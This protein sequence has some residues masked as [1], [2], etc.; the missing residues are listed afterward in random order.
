MADGWSL[1]DICGTDT[2]RKQMKMPPT[3]IMNPP[4]IWLVEAL[5]SGSMPFCFGE[6]TDGIAQRNCDDSLISEE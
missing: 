5:A 6:I 1:S 3:P 4:P 2:S